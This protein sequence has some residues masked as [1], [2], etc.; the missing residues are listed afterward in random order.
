[1]PPPASDEGK[2]NGYL[3]KMEIEKE[4]VDEDDRILLQM[5]YK[6]EL[7]RGFNGFMSFS[8][9]LLP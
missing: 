8:F 7:R 4:P 6:Q 2:D 5:G 9:C 3:A 1:M